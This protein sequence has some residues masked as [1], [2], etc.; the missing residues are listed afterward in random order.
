MDKVC[1]LKENLTIIRECPK[2]R[3]GRAIHCKSSPDEKSGC[4]LSVV[5]PHAGKA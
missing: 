1:L 3:K 2:L 4:G 5:I